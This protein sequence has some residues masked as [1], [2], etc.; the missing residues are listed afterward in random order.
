M[1]HELPTYVLNN[2]NWELAWTHSNDSTDVAQLSQH[3]LEMQKTP[4]QIGVSG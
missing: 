2:D 1:S 3:N 4:D